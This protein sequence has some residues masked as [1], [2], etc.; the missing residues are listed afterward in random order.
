MAGKQ[1]PRGLYGAAYDGLGDPERVTIEERAH[2]PE[3]GL[4]A[5]RQRRS[6]ASPLVR[7][8]QAATDKALGRRKGR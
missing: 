3:S 1:V 6:S 8:L 4:I 2:R 7:A 5:E